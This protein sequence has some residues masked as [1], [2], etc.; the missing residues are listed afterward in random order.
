MTSKDS[1]SDL[2]TET[3]SCQSKSNLRLFSKSFCIDA[4]LARNDPITITSTSPSGESIGSPEDDCP[5]SPIDCPPSSPNSPIITS[6]STTTS[7]SSSSSSAS[8]AGSS[9]A[10]NSNNSKKKKSSSSD[11][12]T[13]KPRRARTAFTYEQLVALENKF[14]S[15]R[16]LSVCERLNLAVNLHLSE[17][18]VK[19]WFQNRRTK[20]K[21]QN[22]GMD[23]NSPTVPPSPTGS[24]CVSGPSSSSTSG[25]SSGASGFMGSPYSSAALLYASQ[26]SLFNSSS[27]G[28]V[29][30]SSPTPTTTLPFNA[31][32]HFNHASAHSLIHHLIHS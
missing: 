6:T 15:T 29:A 23:A 12:K 5:L 14:K 24:L 17:T 9:G 28:S 13:G 10:N 16:Y 22:P 31:H 2:K 11:S 7:S 26:L 4:L 21:K 20:W 1:T 32:Q 27:V 30:S 19:I 3:L 18:Q 8:S 25:L